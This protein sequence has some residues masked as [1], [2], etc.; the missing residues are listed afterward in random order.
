M[1]RQEWSLGILSK[2]ISFCTSLRRPITIKPI[3]I[4]DD[5]SGAVAAH[6]TDKD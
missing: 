2:K 5:L 6:K 4:K 1:Q 3:R